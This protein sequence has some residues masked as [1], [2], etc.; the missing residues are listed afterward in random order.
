MDIQIIQ[1]IWE[2]LYTGAP[3]SVVASSSN[4]NHTIVGKL[5]DY[6][7]KPKITNLVPVYINCSETSPIAVEFWKVVFKSIW[8]A[9]SPYLD[10]E[11]Q[12]ELMAFSDGIEMADD[13]PEVY[14]ILESF[15]R[16]ANNKTGHRILLIL[17]RFDY[18][19][20][21][22]NEPE[23]MILRGIT[24]LATVLSISNK[25]LEELGMEK[26]GNAYYCNQFTPPDPFV[27]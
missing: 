3:T 7:P 2:R 10:N 26:Y 24:P 25:Y 13:V 6:N 16:E 1:N 20:H 11:L 9:F 12:Q 18:L 15:L 22:Q 23:I 8:E 14:I 5:L 17:D 19:V 21:N 4:D 27:I